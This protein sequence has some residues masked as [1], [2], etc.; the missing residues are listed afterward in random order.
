MGDILQ[1]A[2]SS[3]TLPFCS[4]LIYHHLTLMIMMMPLMIMIMEMKMAMMVMKMRTK[5][6]LARKGW[7]I[8]WRWQEALMLYGCLPP[9][10]HY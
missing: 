5:L 4:L 10:P 7:V 1:V 2:G 6:P 3:S 9:T 8:Y